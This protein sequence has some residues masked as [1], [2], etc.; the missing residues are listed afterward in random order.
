MILRQLFVKISYAM[1]KDKC[2][3]EKNLI[4]EIK[5]LSKIITKSIPNI[6]K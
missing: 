3:F 1:Y 4:L 6:S 5:P 2:F